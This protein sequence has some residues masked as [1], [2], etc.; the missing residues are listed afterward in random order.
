MLSSLWDS[1]CTYNKAC[2]LPFF[3]GVVSEFLFPEYLCKAGQLLHSP[4]FSCQTVGTAICIYS[5][6]QS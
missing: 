1:F 5:E 6:K 3:S 2:I 4:E